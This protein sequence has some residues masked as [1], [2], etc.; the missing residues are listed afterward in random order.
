MVQVKRVVQAVPVLVLQA[1]QP[2]LVMQVLL[3]VLVVQK[4]VPPGVVPA[5]GPER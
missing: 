3:V 4:P 5:A 1:V 2:I